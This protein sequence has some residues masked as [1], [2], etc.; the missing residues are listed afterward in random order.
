V[1]DLKPRDH[2]LI[3]PTCQTPVER[4][5]NQALTK[6]DCSL[7]SLRIALSSPPTSSSLGDEKHVPSFLLSTAARD[8]ESVVRCQ[9]MCCAKRAD[10][11]DECI[12]RVAA[13]E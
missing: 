12:G 2:P 11:L 8:P 13:E 7:R 3:L 10:D 9:W 4:W 1:P 6:F 5:V